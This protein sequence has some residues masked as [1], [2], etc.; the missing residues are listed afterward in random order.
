MEPKI[1]VLK[2]SL[3]K[4]GKVLAYLNARVTFPV[5]QKAEGD[6]SGVSV[7][8][9]TLSSLKVI[10]GAKGKFVEAPARKFKDQ[11]FVPFYF[12]NKP[13]KDAITTACLTAYEA[14][15]KEGK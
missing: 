10:D 14:K 9:I 13:M 2:V 5:S 15:V 12:L 4:K 7:F 8:G 11:G 1:E 3:G 6:K